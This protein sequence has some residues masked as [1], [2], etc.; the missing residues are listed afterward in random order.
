MGRAL[1]CPS[2]VPAWEVQRPPP[3]RRPGDPPAGSPPAGVSPSAVQ[4]SGVT[5]RFPGHGSLCETLSFPRK[6][7]FPPAFKA[8]QDP[9]FTRFWGEFTKDAVA[10][11]WPGFT[12]TRRRQERDPSRVTGTAFSADEANDKELAQGF[13]FI[14][15]STCYQ[16]GSCSVIETVSTRSCWQ[17]RPGDAAVE[18]GSPRR[19]HLVPSQV[20]PQCTCQNS[21]RSAD[22]GTSAILYLSCQRPAALERLLSRA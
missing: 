20:N 10:V 1:G 15:R 18:C 7:E 4:R 16:D 8:E 12:G 19:S 6:I 5:L 13:L 21:S 22:E 14:V 11:A 2:P 9:G 17:A 3:K